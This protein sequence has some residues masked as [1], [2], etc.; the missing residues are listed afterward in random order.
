[1]QKKQ[2]TPETALTAGK[3]TDVN[4][5]DKANPGD[6]TTAKSNQRQLEKGKYG[7]APVK[8]FKPAP[9]EEST[10]SNSTQEHK[11]GNE[12]AKE[13]SWI[14]IELVGE[15]DK[16]MAG[17]KYRIILPDN[18]TDEGTLNQKGLVRIEG[19][20]PGMCQVTFPDLDA[21]LWEEI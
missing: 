10:I 2:G 16:P 7:S 13:T 8:P 18:T 21:D 12:K 3:P 15:D 6:T 20:N 17:E 11:E 1:V 14:E 4:E 5:S 9:E 19:F